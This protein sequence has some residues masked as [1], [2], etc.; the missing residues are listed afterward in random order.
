MPI[1]E[2]G[3]GPRVKV[4][5]ALPASPLCKAPTSVARE[6]PFAGAAAVWQLFPLAHGRD[7]HSGPDSTVLGRD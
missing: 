2:H 7:R 3:S 1:L 6:L 4:L 5:T